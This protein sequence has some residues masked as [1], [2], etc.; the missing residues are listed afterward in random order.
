MKRTGL[1]YFALGV[2]TVLSLGAVTN[3]LVPLT[4]DSVGISG[5]G[6]TFPDG[7]EQTTAAASATSAVPC[8]CL[9]GVGVGFEY[10][11]TCRYGA[12]DS[13]FTSVPTGQVL[14][15]KDVLIQRNNLATTGLSIV[16]LGRDSGSTIPSGLERLKFTG[17][18]EAA[19]FHFEAPFLVLE[20]GEALQ[21]YNSGSSSFPIDYHIS[22]LLA[23]DATHQL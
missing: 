6:I 10:T 5:T 3:Q 21:V 14:M 11:V 13:S 7:T 9:G 15:V 18:P 12:G 17:G 19:S 4:T 1:L 22:C 23:P 2:K 20:A 16:Y 8:Y